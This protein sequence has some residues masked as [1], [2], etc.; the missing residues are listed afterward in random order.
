MD[1]HLKQLW[2][3]QTEHPRRNATATRT[4]SSESLKQKSGKRAASPHYVGH[5][6][7]EIEPSDDIIIIIII[8]II[9]TPICHILQIFLSG[10]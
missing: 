9:I 4:A 6:Q 2:A 5:M 3:T 10:L 8:I 1:P 7:L